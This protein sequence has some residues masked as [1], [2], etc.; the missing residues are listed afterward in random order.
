[1]IRRSKETP[2]SIRHYLKPD[3]DVLEE[4]HTVQAS[5]PVDLSILHVK[6]HQDDTNVPLSDLPL[7]AQLNIQADCATLAAYNLST[8][9]EPTPTI[10][11]TGAS[12]TFGGKRITSNLASTLTLCL[13]YPHYGKRYC[14][15]YGWHSDVFHS[16]AWESSERKYKRLSYCRRLAS[17][18]LQ[19]GLWPTN[20]TILRRR[21]DAPSLLCSRCA[22][23]VETHDHVLCCS[24]AQSHRLAQWS[25]V[26]TTLREA[27]STPKALLNALE[28]GICSWQ[29]GEDIIS[30]PFPY[31]SDHVGTAI[32]ATFQAQALIGW[33]HAL[34][35]H[36][37]THWGTAMATYRHLC[38]NDTHFQ[39][40]N[41]LCIIIWALHSYTYS[42]WTERN[43]TMHGATSQ[44]NYVLQRQSLQ[45]DV[46]AA[47]HNQASVPSS[48]QGHLFD[49]SLLLRLDQNN[50][51][52]QQWLQSYRLNQLLVKNQLRQEC[53]SLG[54]IRRFLISRAEGRRPSTPP[55]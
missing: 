1:M 10:P 4:A 43:S 20:Y 22:T 50:S 28:H 49:L 38:F 48:T 9:S 46:T 23:E 36:L 2:H 12:I 33:N 29:E 7:S 6:A 15:K 30:W 24:A 55:D 45:H 35:G 47:Y 14:N 11:L 34:R 3:T 39:A 37:A 32:H 19:Q 16:I 31:P 53:R 42:Q 51:D 40:S 26:T 25:F 44:D 41:W 13:L 5:L 17:F 27:S 8:S 21:K 18:K 54:S 52:L